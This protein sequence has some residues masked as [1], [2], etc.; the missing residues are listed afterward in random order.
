MPISII[1][2]ALKSRIA[3]TA[4][5]RK[6]GGL[7]NLDLNLSFGETGSAG[8]DTGLLGRLS[9]LLS[10]SWDDIKP[11]I[12]RTALAIAKGLNITFQTVAGWVV[13]DATRI[14]TFDWNQT[15][16]QLRQLNEAENTALYAVWGNVV[17]TGLGWV[18][19]VVLGYGVVQAIP[20][21]GTAAL[22]KFIATKIAE[23]GVEETFASV[24]AALTLTSEVQAR[25]QLRNT[26]IYSRRG[27]KRVAAVTGELLQSVRDG[28]RPSGNDILERLAEDPTV[29]P[30]SWSFARGFDNLIDSLPGNWG[31]FAEEAADSF[32][33]A[34]TDATFLIAQE[35]DTFVASQRLTEESQNPERG[36]VLY[37]DRENENERYIL[38]GRQS[39][40]QSQANIVLSNHRTISNRDIGL[41]TGQTLDDY[42]RDKELTLRLRFQLFN[43]KRPPYGNTANDSL[44]RV[45]ITVPDVKRSAISWQKLRFALGGSNGYLWGRFKARGRIDSKRYVTVY[46]G[47][48]SE[49]VRRLKAVMQLSNADIQTINVTEELL[50]GDRLTNPRLQKD[51]TQVYP[52]Y[53][54]IINRDRTLAIDQGRASTDGR[55]ADRQNRFDLWR[56]TEPRGFDQQVAELF[57]YSDG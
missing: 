4:I 30:P 49:A 35:L 53:V 56:D 51:T 23:E 19:S 27:V 32:A 38:T 50:E 24:A 34:L 25:K 14:W 17:G 26:Y 44:T 41:L 36:I 20:V 10:T 37:P 54:S 9:R 40:V 57:R 16:E 22:A 55:W 6:I 52:G 18:T 39:D 33:D 43:R 29:T 46:G 47:S 11:F 21:I 2:T 42:V 5:L 15:D 3:R 8:A 45:T 7:R 31:I 48:E 1:K 12:K 28:E 13:N